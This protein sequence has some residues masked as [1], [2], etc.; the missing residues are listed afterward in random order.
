VQDPTAPTPAQYNPPLTWRGH[1]WRTLL[2]LLIWAIVAISAAPVRRAPWLFGLDLAV[3]AATLVLS[4]FRRRWPFSVGMVTALAG[5]VSA[6]AAGPGTLASVSLATRRNLAQVVAVGVAGMVGAQVFW[7]TQPRAAGSG[8]WWLDLGFAL[9][10]TI[11]MLV[12][13]MYIGSRRELLWT[14]RDRAERAEAE[15]ELRVQQA[16][17]TERARIAREMH[18]VLAHRISLVTMHAGALAYRT[19]LSPE[20]VHTTAGIIQ[21]KSHEA[22][23]DLRQVLGVLR[24]QEDGGPSRPQPTFAD[25]PALVEEAQES[26]MRVCY[27]AT[28]AGRVPEQVGRTTYRIVQEG[29]TNARKHAPGAAVEV[30]LSG[31]ADEGVRISVR[32]PARA[33]RRLVDTPGA[34]L[35]LVGLAERAKLAGGRIE[36]ASHDGTFELRGWLPWQP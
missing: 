15:Q 23:D 6:S 24:G 35:G 10:F 9:A 16:R 29:L 2:V 13:G 25:L 3:G 32:N 33:V 21:A 4:F 17:S 34:G 8:P 27:T 30:T 5:A 18:D 20:E 22:L 36:T 12:S 7:M 19:D 31:S 28:V 1:A 14:L 11:A 26:G